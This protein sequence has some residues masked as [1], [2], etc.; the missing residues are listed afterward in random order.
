[1]EN[2]PPCE[3]ER[4]VCRVA[5]HFRRAKGMLQKDVAV[6]MGVSRSV[7]TKNEGGRHLRVSELHRFCRAVEIRPVD[8]LDR[9][10]DEMERVEKEMRK[11]RRT[12]GVS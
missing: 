3:V 4:C 10:E 7:V 9:M 11:R 6:L 8:F 2:L 12:G 1:M 5:E